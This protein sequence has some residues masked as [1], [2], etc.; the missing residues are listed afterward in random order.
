MPVDLLLRAGALHLERRDGHT[1]G[2]EEP[3]ATLARVDLDD[4]QQLRVNAVD[5]VALVEGV[6]DDLPVAVD[7]FAHVHDGGEL[8]EVVGRQQL[9]HFGTKELGERRRARDRDS[10]R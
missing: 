5:V 9:G 6:H 7:G 8:V 3:V 10:R 4:A 2:L 1:V